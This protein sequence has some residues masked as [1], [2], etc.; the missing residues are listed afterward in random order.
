MR[1]SRLPLVLAIG[2]SLCASEVALANPI[3]Y[4]QRQSSYVEINFGTNQTS[5]IGSLTIFFTTGAFKGSDFS[6]EYAL[7]YPFGDLYSISTADASTVHIGHVQV[8]GLPS[9]MR[10]DPVSGQMFLM[11]PDGSCNNSTLY[12]IDVSDASTHEIG[13]TGGCIVT[14]AI[15]TQGDAYGVDILSN[16]LVSIDKSS[17]A[18]TAIGS[19]LGYSLR[20]F[21]AFDFAG[22]QLI[23][24]A[25]DIGSGV[26]SY[27]IVDTALG[28]A[29]L[30]SPYP[31]QYSAFAM[32]PA[33][34]PIF[35][36]GFDSQ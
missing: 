33:L 34:D 10:W 22:G 21:S 5:V 29:Q 18:A 16:S 25:E 8:T 17:G 24:I 12:A 27:F 13:S 4:A 7:D 31:D 2:A 3:A 19:G 9:A 11:A 20:E 1:A 35:V 26:N 28:S 30:V 15:D 6:E 14:L 23:L 36:N 32:A